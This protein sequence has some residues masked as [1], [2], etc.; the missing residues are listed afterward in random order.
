M[1]QR[2]DFHGPA[3]LS[4][5]T[6][7]RFTFDDDDKIIAFELDQGR[8][9]AFAP[10]NTF[11]VRFARWFDEN[12]CNT[13]IADR[14]FVSPRTVERYVSAVLTKM[15][16]P[17]RRDMHIPGCRASTL[18]EVGVIA[19]TGRP[20]SRALSEAGDIVHIR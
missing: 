19:R 14:L 2:D 5:E 11:D 4:V 13:E 15:D 8:A 1:R 17:T 3:G 6:L 9:I 7:Y 16:A 12:L 18:V 20:R 10:W